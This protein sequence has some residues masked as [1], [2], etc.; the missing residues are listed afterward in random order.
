KSD[1]L[2]THSLDGAGGALHQCRSRIVN[3]VKGQA[4]FRFPIE[5]IEEPRTGHY[6]VEGVSRRPAH[7][8]RENQPQIGVPAPPECS[9]DVV[10]EIN[11]ST[12]FVPDHDAWTGRFRC[13][14]KDKLHWI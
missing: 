11:Y 7:S 12:R 2:P 8:V 10:A 4:W 14:G 1:F 5:H 13:F 9:I 3:Q 6:C